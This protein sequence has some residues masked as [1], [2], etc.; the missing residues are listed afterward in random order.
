VN[1]TRNDPAGRARR[2]GMILRRCRTLTAARVVEHLARLEAKHGQATPS[3]EGIAK[4][5][6]RC[7]RSVSRAVGELEAAGALRVVRDRPHCRQDGTWARH[8]T[9]LYRLTW[10][11]KDRVVPGGTEG[12]RVSRLCDSEAIEPGRRRP[13]AARR[14]SRSSALTLFDPDPRPPD[15]PVG[16]A[17]YIVLGISMREWVKRCQAGEYD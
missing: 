4:A 17:P 14:S 12:T 5:I 10:P 1:P 6:G 3:R 2:L 7:E 11:P 9:N 16:P 15:D 13:Q 8:R